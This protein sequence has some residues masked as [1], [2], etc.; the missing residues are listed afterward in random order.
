MRKQKILEIL[1]SGEYFHS[2]RLIHHI[3][4]NTRFYLKINLPSI[5]QPNNFLDNLARLATAMLRRNARVKNWLLA[6]GQ[7][8]MKGVEKWRCSFRMFT[9]FCPCEWIYLERGSALLHL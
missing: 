9:T 2:L 3:C 8:M 1:L 4:I 7:R 6:W 5:R